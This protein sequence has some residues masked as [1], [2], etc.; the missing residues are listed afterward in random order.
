MNAKISVFVI[1]VKAIMYLLLKWRNH[2]RDTK[3]Y[4]E[5]ICNQSPD[6][7]NQIPSEFQVH[8]QPPVVL[9]KFLKGS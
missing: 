6:L 4:I 5:N 9:F 1:C 8:K 3:Y 2:N 7:Y